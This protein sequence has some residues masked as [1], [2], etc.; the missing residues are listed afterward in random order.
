[1]VAQDRP[2]RSTLLMTMATVSQARLAKLAPIHANEARLT[3]ITV[4][5]RPFRAA[6]PRIEAE[7]LGDKRIVH[8]YG[9]GGSGW[10]LSWGSGEAALRLALAGRDPAHTDLAV[11]GCGA[12]GLTAA[13]LGQRAGCHSVTIYAKDSPTESRSFRATGSW[14]P[15]SRLA[16]ASV[17]LP[18]FA[19][20]WEQMTRNSWRHFHALIAEPKAA[21]TFNDRFTPSDLHPDAFDRE[22]CA[23]NPLGFAIYRDRVADLSQP[24]EDFGPGSH[25]FPTTWVR[26][27]PEMMFD[28]TRLVAR[29]VDEF[30]Y[31]GGVLERREFHTPN[32]LVHLRQPVIL[33]CTGY[34]A[35]KL[36]GDDSLVPIL[37]QIGWLPPQPEVN[38]GLFLDDLI[39]LARPDG[40][41]VQNSHHTDTTGWNDQ[42]E[43]AELEE[44]RSSLR[45][46]RSFFEP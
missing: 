34:A 30:Q 5:T 7:A 20:H 42:N 12:L 44:T 11:I 43:T 39:V 24:A 14:T 8:N 13:I 26:R 2:Q 36:F 23:L 28:I 3:K 32:D 9:H 37:G 6:G 10:S 18:A 25:Q 21:V 19:S 38:Y 45:Q 29:L 15:D 4:C 46:L 40:I 31:Q 16:L 1:M 35:R 33:N 41:A 17:A 27:R 22:R